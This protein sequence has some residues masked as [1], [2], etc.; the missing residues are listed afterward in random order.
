MVKLCICC[1]L[2][3]VDTGWEDQRRDILTSWYVTNY[4]SFL[5]LTY[6]N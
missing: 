2:Q 6:N 5:C 3:F 4:I 1:W